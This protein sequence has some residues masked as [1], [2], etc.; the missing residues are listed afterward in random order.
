MDDASGK[1]ALVML[2]AERVRVQHKR[3]K[4]EKYVDKERILEILCRDC[5]HQIVRPGGHLQKFANG[6]DQELDLN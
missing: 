5:Y 4:H 3:T 6:L 1:F 2:R